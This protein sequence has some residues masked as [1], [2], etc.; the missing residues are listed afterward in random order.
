MNRVVYL[1]GYALIFLGIIDMTLV[2]STL[3]GVIYAQVP[4]FIGLALALHGRTGSV[5][6]QQQY[7]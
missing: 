5:Q 2:S 7:R 3:F 4:I 1:F 6:P